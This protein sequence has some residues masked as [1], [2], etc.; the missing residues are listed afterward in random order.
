MKVLIFSIHTARDKIYR[1]TILI[2][3]IG[4]VFKHNVSMLIRRI[5]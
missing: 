4:K 2:L 5:I 3:D 1:I